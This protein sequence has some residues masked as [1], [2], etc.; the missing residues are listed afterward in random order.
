MTATFLGLSLALAGLFARPTPVKL[1]ES[2]VVPRLEKRADGTNVLELHTLVC[3]IHEG[4]P[5]ALPYTAKVPAECEKVNRVSAELRRKNFKRLR[6]RA[7]KYLIRSVNANVP[8]ATGFELRGE[9]DVGLPRVSATEIALGTGKEMKVILEPGQY[10]YLDP[11]S[12]SPS[13][14]LLVER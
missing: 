11:V 14:E 12:K 8:W 6:I 3:V 1:P 4:E 2:D 13:Y 7:G 5:D 9:L 10:V